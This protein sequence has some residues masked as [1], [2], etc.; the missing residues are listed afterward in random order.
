ML[1]IPRPPY[2]MLG[3]NEQLR[4]QTFV[5]LNIGPE[6]G[7]EGKK[8]EVKTATFPTLLTMIVVSGCFTGSCF[9]DFFLGFEVP[10][11]LAKFLRQGQGVF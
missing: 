5:L 4:P 9:K 11:K 1:N 10:R 7:E 6:A 3:Y 8:K 2:S